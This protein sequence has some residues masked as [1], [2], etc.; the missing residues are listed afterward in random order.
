MGV[1]VLILLEYA[2]K[3]NWWGKVGMWKSKG[4]LR[5]V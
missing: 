5:M 2:G 3:M 1:K 4:D